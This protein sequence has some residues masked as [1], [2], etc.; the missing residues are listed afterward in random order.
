MVCKT[1]VLEIGRRLVRSFLNELVKNEAVLLE[2]IRTGTLPLIQAKEGDYFDDILNS[3]YEI[4]RLEYKS[5]ELFGFLVYSFFNWAQFPVFVFIMMCL[6]SLSVIPMSGSSIAT[7]FILVHSYVLQQ[8]YQVIT[9]FISI[10]PNSC[11][12]YETIKGFL[13]LPRTAID[14]YRF[15]ADFKPLLEKDGQILALETSFKELLTSNV[16]LKLKLD[17]EY[18]IN[19]KEFKVTV[20]F[21]EWLVQFM[22]SMSKDL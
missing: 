1:S 5:T 7:V 20:P 16:D 14:W 13:D 17:K 19:E 22:K 11:H 21:I 2:K 6:S 10:S 12:E 4:I 15:R 9:K 3:F 18:G 8:D